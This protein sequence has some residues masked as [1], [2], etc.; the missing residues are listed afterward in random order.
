MKTTMSLYQ[1]LL[2]P[3]LFQMDPEKAH[4]LALKAV[5]KGLIKVSVQ[6]R[7]ELVREVFGVK[8]PNPIGLAAGFDKNGVA[9][10]KWRDLGFGFIEVGTVTRHAQPGNPKP[11]MFRFPESKAV[12]NRLG[13]NNEGADALAARLE[14][15]QPGIP[16][17]INLGKSKITPLEEAAEDYAYSFN[18]L[19]AWGDYFVVNVSSPNTPGLRQLQDKDALTK[20]L[21]RLKEIDGAKPLFVKIAPDLEVP[22]IEEIVEL[23]IDMGLTGLIATNTTLSRAGLP[24]DPGQ[25]GGLS[26]AP[27]TNRSLE[28]LQLV[29][30]LAG[31]RLSLIG[32]GG[33]MNAKDAQARLDAGADLIQTYTG[34]IYG[35]PGFVE[36]LKAGLA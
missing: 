3:L 27:L 25:D 2:R 21:W 33:I 34:W 10:D 15:A 5:R 22:Q 14:T 9:L 28:V 18:R 19:K 31:D 32:V 13:F 6:N 30:S 29:K 16:L 26:G 7:P 11:R 23:S 12:I 36:D 4:N 20:I 1:S 24:R 35:G 17:G 8:F